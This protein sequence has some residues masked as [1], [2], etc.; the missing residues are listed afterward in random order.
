VPSKPLVT[1]IAVLA[2]VQSVFCVM[3]ALRWFDIGVGSESANYDLSRRRAENV[4]VYL[5][6]ERNIDAA[7]VLTVAYGQKVPLADNKTEAGR[8]KNRRIEILVY[9][10]S[11]DIGSA[12]DD[13]AQR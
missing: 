11:I 5:T 8:T 7:R 13:K 9:R 2:I 6:T 1:I 12:A 10:D 4:A 3:R